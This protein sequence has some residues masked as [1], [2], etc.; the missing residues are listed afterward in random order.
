MAL[1]L[2]P[3]TGH[4]F[5]AAAAAGNVAV[6]D[7]RRDAIVATVPVA[8]Q[9]AAMAIDSRTG[10]VYVTSNSTGPASALPIDRAVTVLRDDRRPFRLLGALI[11]D[12]SPDRIK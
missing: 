8:A 1:A 2:N 9:P 10:L 11:A 4:L 3:A 7:T 6:V 5:V 12:L